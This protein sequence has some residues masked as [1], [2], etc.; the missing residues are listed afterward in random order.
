MARLSGTWTLRA[1]EKESGWRQGIL[2]A[3]SAAHDGLHELLVGDEIAGVQG[4]EVTVT[5]QAFDPARGWTDCLQLER[6]AWEDSVGV[7]VTISAD[8]NPPQGDRDFNDLVVLCLPEDPELRTPHSFPRPDL[9]VPESN[10]R[11]D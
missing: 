8:D 1:I 6:L 7:T 5:P 9:T 10:V 4:D 3:G 11:P 2:I